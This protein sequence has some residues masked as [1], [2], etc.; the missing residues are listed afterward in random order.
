M[1]QAKIVEASLNLL[2]QTISLQTFER[3]PS[4][5]FDWSILEYLV[6]TVAHKMTMNER[7][8]ITDLNH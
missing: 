5:N 1:D 2:K 6:P 7:L 3:L 8:D 4:M